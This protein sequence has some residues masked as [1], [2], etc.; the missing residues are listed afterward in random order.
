MKGWR[1]EI[2]DIGVNPAD[3]GNGSGTVG[4]PGVLGF[5]RAWV[6][7]VF[8]FVKGL[9]D[10]FIGLCGVVWDLVRGKKVRGARR[11]DVLGPSAAV[12]PPIPQERDDDGDGM[13][14]ERFSTLR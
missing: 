8:I 5:S 6:R 13:L 7:Q 11:V 3:N 12:A 9:G 4:V 14:Y 10:V 2:R 1:N